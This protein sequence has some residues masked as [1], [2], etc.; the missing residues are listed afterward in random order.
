VSEPFD[1]FRVEH[2]GIRWLQSAATLEEARARV[3]E[4]AASSG[5]EFFV[6]NQRTGNRFVI[7]GD[8]AFAIAG[9]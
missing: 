7:K 9:V 2:L 6:L 8:G 1:I 4:Q 3:Q 5:G